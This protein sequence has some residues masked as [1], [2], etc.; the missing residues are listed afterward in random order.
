MT[1][2]SIAL[3]KSIYKGLGHVGLLKN[4]YWYIVSFYLF[5]TA[6][7]LSI[8]A[9]YKIISKLFKKQTFK[10]KNQQHQLII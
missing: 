3:M 2:R 6:F 7:F 4:F 10:H 8:V 9:I 1:S 5:L